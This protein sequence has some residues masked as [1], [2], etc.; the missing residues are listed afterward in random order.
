[1]LI[2]RETIIIIII[3]LN[4]CYCSLNIHMYEFVRRTAKYHL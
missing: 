1:M 2:I 3:I 4:I